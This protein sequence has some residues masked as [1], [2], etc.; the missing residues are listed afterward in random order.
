MNIAILLAA[1]KSSRAKQNKIRADIHGVELW[2]LA[3]DTFR[4]HKDI[5][6]MI[7]VVPKNM[8]DFFMENAPDAQIIVGGESRMQSFKNGV[9]AIDF[10]SDDIIIDHNA[11]NPNVTSGEITKV[12]IA[13]K[14][15]GGAAVYHSV[16]DTVINLDGEVLDRDK[17]KLMQTPQA[18]R[19]DILKD[20]TLH[21]ETDLSSAIFKKYTLHLLEAH[22]ANKKVTYAEDIEQLR[23]RAFIG[24]DSHRFS[25]TGKLTLG[26]LTVEDCPAME[27]NSDGDVILHAIGRALAQEQDKS[28]SRIAD[29]L[30][31]AGEKDSRKYLEGLLKDSKINRISLQIEGL[32]PRI[33]SL[34]LRESLSEILNI[35]SGKIQISAMTGEGLSP[36]GRGEGLRCTCILQCF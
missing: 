34:P 8:E 18:I 14:E 12:I 22:P 3:Y 5:D 16:V 25:D 28:F 27:A 21:N 30:C 33:D 10:S 4:T 29:E 7:L 23:S 15:H 9:A 19:G 11:A 26:G 20:V 13:A 1:G 31:Q 36:F 17:L 6:K 24:E 32:K 35:D 2:T